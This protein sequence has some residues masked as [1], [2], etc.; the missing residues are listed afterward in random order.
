MKSREG[1]FLG[2]DQGTVVVNLKAISVLLRF[3]LRKLSKHM[4]QC[5]AAKDLQL[6]YQV[7]IQKLASSILNAIEC[8]Y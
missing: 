6:F 5:M 4:S 7:E 8:Q 1:W 3:H 2:E